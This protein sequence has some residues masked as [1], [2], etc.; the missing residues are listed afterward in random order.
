MNPLV[1]TF[2]AS[3]VCSD[4]ALSFRDFYKQFYY[5][6]SDASWMGHRAESLSSVTIRVMDAE[7]DF[8]DYRMARIEKCR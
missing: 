4:P 1:I 2:I 8:I 7:A 5:P 6:G 3:L